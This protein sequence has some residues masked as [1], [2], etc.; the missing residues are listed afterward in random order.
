M[1]HLQSVYDFKGALFFIHASL[2]ILCVGYSVNC[3]V[4]SPHDPFG[5]S[6]G[7][8]QDRLPL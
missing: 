6:L 3:F 5:I 8:E 7:A 4:V 1:I 2:N